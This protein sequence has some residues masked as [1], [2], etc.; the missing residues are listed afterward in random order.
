M[1]INCVYAACIEMQ[2]KNV[3]DEICI[4]VAVRMMRIT[5]KNTGR[6]KTKNTELYVSYKILNRINRV[7]QKRRIVANASGDA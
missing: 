6:E 2:H 7:Q 4:A 3:D 5:G 1:I